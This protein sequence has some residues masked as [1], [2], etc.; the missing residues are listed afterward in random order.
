MIS[1]LFKTILVLA[2]LPA[3]AMAQDTESPATSAD[4]LWRNKVNFGFNFNQAAFS[5]NWTGGGVNSVAF[6]SLLNAAANYKKDQWSW[7]NQADLLFGVINNQGTG[8]RKSQDRVYLD[9]KVGYRISDKWNGY[10][11]LSFLTQFAPG[12][13]YEELATGGED[14]RLISD[15][16]AP[17]FLT[18]SLGFEY[19]PNE[20]FTLRL[21]PFSPRVTFVTDTTIINNVPKNYGVEQGKMIRYEWFALQL[22][23]EYIKDL[24]E[25]INLQTR[26]QLFANYENL[27]ADQVDHRFDATISAQ[28]T[29]FINLSLSAIMIYDFD[30]VDE[31]QFSQLLG[32]GILLQKEGAVTE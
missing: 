3:V 17:G 13:R 9:S 5:D 16:L 1:T 23:A 26:Y 19:V 14:A 30:Q 7:N 28:L 6:S 4:T 22:Q 21:S 32:I 29:K 24:T 12:Y 18:S 10:G 31:V 8:F 27:S 25:N 2:L 11:S 15:F 20:N